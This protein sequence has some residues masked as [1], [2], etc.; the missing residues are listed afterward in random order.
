MSEERDVSDF[1]SVVFASEG[2]V[3]ISVGGGE[4]LSV[5]AD[6]NLQQYLETSVDGAILTI[7]TREGV[8]IAPSESPV[9]RVEARALTAVSLTGAGSIDIDAVD[10]ERFEISLGGVGDISVE[11]VAVNALSADLHGVGTLLL[12]GKA[13]RQ[14]LIVGGV[15][16][17]EGG[18]LA[19]RFTA[20]DAGDSGEATIWVSESLDVTAS[21][22]ASVAYFGSPSVS[23]QVSDSAGVTAL[24]PK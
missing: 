17:Y 2:S 13:D 1:E 16:V 6:D 18:E 11:S 4:A 7:A 22:T 21:G 12:T 14:D 8:D 15:T 19:S 3:I 5:E 9:F 24:G 23:E 10:S 20:I